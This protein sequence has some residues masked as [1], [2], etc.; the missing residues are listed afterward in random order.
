MA[1][2]PHSIIF[3]KIVNSALVQVQKPADLHILHYDG[4]PFII[5]TTPLGKFPTYSDVLVSKKTANK[6]ADFLN[7]TFGTY[8][9][10]AVSLKEL[11]DNN[12]KKK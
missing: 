8:L 9:F 6:H 7:E 11:I 2:I 5:K 10:R 12:N 1:R 4:A 3:E